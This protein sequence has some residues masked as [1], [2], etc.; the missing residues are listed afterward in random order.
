MLAFEEIRKLSREMVAPQLDSGTLADHIH[1]VI[2][3]IELSTDLKIK[4]T[5]DIEIELL[6]PGKKLTLFRIVQEQVKNI[7]RYSEATKAEIL[8]QCSNNNTQLIIKDDGIGFDTEKTNSGIGLSSIRDR[9]KFY[10]GKTEINSAPGKGCQ[11]NITIP[12]HG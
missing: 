12:L 2:A 7:T 11:L 5:H 9:V 10:N 4:F 8:L 3:D 1:K 6:S